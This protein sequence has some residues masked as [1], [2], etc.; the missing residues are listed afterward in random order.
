MFLRVRYMERGATSCGPS[1]SW[2]A[3]SGLHR[4]QGDRQAGRRPHH[5]GRTPDAARLPLILPP[6]PPQ[7]REEQGLDDRQ[8][9]GQGQRGRQ[10]PFSRESSDRPRSRGPRVRSCR[11]RPWAGWCFRPGRCSP[12]FGITDAFG[13]VRKLRLYHN[14]NTRAW[15]GVDVA[16]DFFRVYHLTVDGVRLRLAYAYTTRFQTTT[17][18]LQRPSSLYELGAVSEKIQPLAQ[19]AD[20]FQR[21]TLSAACDLSGALRGG[22]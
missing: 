5:Q 13:A 8:S 19:S 14:G 1:F 16:H 7:K 15:P 20:G 6:P 9:R 17:V 4:P 11:G 18:Y 12:N 21:P 22:C 3:T 2:A 10:P